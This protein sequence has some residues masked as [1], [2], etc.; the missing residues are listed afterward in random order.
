MVDDA[1][2]MSLRVLLYL[3]YALG[4]YFVVVSLCS[5][6]A[7]NS[8]CKLVIETLHNRLIDS[9]VLFVKPPL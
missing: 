4:L 6:C 7:P 2:Q 9:V 1:F 3:L 8:A 5:A